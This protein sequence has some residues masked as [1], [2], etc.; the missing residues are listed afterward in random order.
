MS[1]KS[2]STPTPTDPE[3]LVVELLSV[4]PTPTASVWSR[5]KAFATSH[6]VGLG[7]VGAFVAGAA[8]MVA[9]GNLAEEVDEES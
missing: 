7:V 4:E 6:K 1:S 8:A 9:L 5:A 2:N 3:Q